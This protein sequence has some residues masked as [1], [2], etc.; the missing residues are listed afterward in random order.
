MNNKKMS[1][2]EIQRW[3]EY[4]RMVLYPT[5]EEKAELEA[6]C[7]KLDEQFKRR[8][9]ERKRRIQEQYTKALQQ[10]QRPKE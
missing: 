6:K 3:A 7:R 8:T 1:E 4:S 9:V 5:P 10:Q 2:E